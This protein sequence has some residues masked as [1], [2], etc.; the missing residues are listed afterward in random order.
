MNWDLPELEAFLEAVTLHVDADVRVID[1]PHGLGV[2]R[3]TATTDDLDSRL[4]ARATTGLERLRLVHRLD[5]ETAGCLVLAASREAA[6]L[7]GR[8]FA[9]RR[10]VKTYWAL[11]HGVPEPRA[12]VIDLPLIKAGS[13]DGDRVRP[14]RPDEIEAAWSAVTHYE[15]L[16]ARL[17]SFAFVRLTPETGRQHQIRAHLAAIGPPI[18][19]DAKYP[20]SHAH[21]TD[22]PE[23]L[24]LLARRLVF[25]H[26]RG[27]MLGVEAPLPPHMRAS[28]ANL[29][30]RLGSARLA[31]TD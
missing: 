26:P 31:T 20:Y 24:H 7:L 17:D 3:G 16:Q 18:V 5:R 29:G 10:V 6:R 12:G 8:E 19:G 4:I 30:E 22:P 25:R 15:V 13:P 2:Q 27:H 9:A 14:A 28:F 11:V 23:K 1:K 21:M